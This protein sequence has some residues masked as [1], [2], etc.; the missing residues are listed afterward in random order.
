MRYDRDRKESYELYD[1]D[2]DP[3]ELTDL[4]NNNP[5][6]TRRLAMALQKAESAGRTRP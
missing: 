4:S 5:D 3:G 2:E 6:V 1:L